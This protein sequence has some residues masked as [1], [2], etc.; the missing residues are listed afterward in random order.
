MDCNWAK[1]L[2]AYDCAPLRTTSGH[3]CVEIGTPFTLP[4]GTAI[5]IY[6]METPSSLMKIS[7][8]GDSLFQFS[9]MGLDVWNAR[10]VA[11]I[12]ELL[13]KHRL[14][15]SEDGNIFML[16]AQNR[17]ASAFAQAVTGFLALAQWAAEQLEVELPEHDLIAEIEPYVI[18]RNPAA[19]F[20]RNPR[21]RGASQ[22]V[23]R[24]DFRHGSDL[25]DVLSPHPAATGAALR[26][27]GDVQNG[28]YAEHLRPL[29]I[30][31]DRADPAHAASEIG[32][33]ASMTRAVPASRVMHRRH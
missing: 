32:I 11:A 22:T 14:A 6:L 24:F 1:A 8:N 10:R 12:R 25:I 7:D 26:K 2:T 23:H 15:M 18:A 19:V 4:D 3:A 31:D 5:N 20:K 28:P 29:F 33:L 30:V 16:T 13:R 21:V 9:G 27:A 17:A